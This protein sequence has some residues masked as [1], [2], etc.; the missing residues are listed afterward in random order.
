[1]NPRSAAVHLIRF[2]QNLIF[3][4]VP[5]CSADSLYSMPSNS[6]SKTSVLF[7]GIAGL[8]LFAP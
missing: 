3:P 6:T 1:M 4:E 2:R 7:G 5:H 8:G